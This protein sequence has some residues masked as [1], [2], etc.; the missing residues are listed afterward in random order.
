[1]ASAVDD[2]ADLALIIKEGNTLKVCRGFPLVR[3]QYY[4]H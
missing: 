4:H 1:M 2:L 3:R